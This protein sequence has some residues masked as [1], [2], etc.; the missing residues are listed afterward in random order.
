MALGFTI[1]V[2]PALICDYSDEQPELLLR[3]NRAVKR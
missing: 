2:A 1:R 3:R